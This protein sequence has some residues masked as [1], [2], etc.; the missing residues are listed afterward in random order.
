[1]SVPLLSVPSRLHDIADDLESVFWVLMFGALKYYAAPG[2]HFPSYLFN[3]YRTDGQGCRVGGLHKEDWVRDRGIIDKL[4]LTSEILHAL[5][6]KCCASWF[7]H[8]SVFRFPSGSDDIAYF[9]VA[10]LSKAG[11]VAD[12]SFWIEKYSAAL[13]S[14][15]SQG[16]ITSEPS[17]P[18][19]ADEDRTEKLANTP[20]SQ[21]P[22]VTEQQSNVV[23][24]A[25]T[26]F[27]RKSTITRNSH[28]R[29]GRDK[30]SP[31]IGIK[32]CGSE[33][34]ADGSSRLPKRAKLLDAE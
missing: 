27:T 2:Q 14:V 13:S 21:N 31:S 4:R 19:E 8:Y 30:S 32:R 16:T 9:D 10:Y 18:R 22:N 23:D 6:Y 1:M 26:G 12:P 3:H 28:N 29:T 11:L 33:D 20:A 25:P 15:D 5:I 17:L 7:L 24:T 34:L